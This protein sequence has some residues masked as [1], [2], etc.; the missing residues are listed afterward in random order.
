MILTLSAEMNDGGKKADSAFLYIK[1][2]ACYV[3]WKCEALLFI[4]YYPFKYNMLTARAA[5]SQ[6][7]Q[8]GEGKIGAF[9]IQ[10]FS[11]TN[12]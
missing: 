12:R 9:E 10:I 8:R 11:Q 7:K 2:Q 6:T 3:F 5:V 4:L 1:N